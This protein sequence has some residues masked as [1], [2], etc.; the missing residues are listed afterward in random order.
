[1][2]EKLRPEDVR[3]LAYHCTEGG[4][5]GGDMTRAVRYTL[6]A[7]EES[8]AA[9]AFADAEVR[10]R[11]ALELLED[12]EDVASAA[13]VAALCGLGEAQR[14]QGDAGF[15]ET[16]LDASRRAIEMSNIDLLVRAVLSNTRGFAS[17][18]GGIDV[19]RLEVIDR[20]LELV[21]TAASPNR[22][23]LLGQLASEL[24]FSGQHE[25]RLALADDAVAMAR[26]FG[27]AVLLGDV[28]VTTGYACNSSDRWEQL[29]DRT[30]ESTR[31]ADA[32]GDPAQRVVARVFL[33][34]ALLTAGRLDESSQVTR[35]MGAIAEAEGSPLIRWIALSNHI[36]V[37]ALAG[38]LDEAEE[39]NDR[40]LALSRELDQHD[41]E[42]WWAA[43]LLGLMWLRGYAG[44][45]ADAAADFA[46]QFPLA[47][48][49]R[50]AQAWLLADAGRHD[51]ARAV[52]RDHALDPAELIVEPWPFTAAAQLALTAFYLGDAELGARVVESIVDHP[53]CWS[54]YYLMVF[55]PLSWSMGLATAA[56]GA[57]DE[58][59]THLERTLVVLGEQGLVA[60][61]PTLR[62]QLAQVLRRRDG[63]GDAERAAS[64]LTAARDEAVAIGAGG[65]VERIDALAEAL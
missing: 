34:S 32:N 65:V 3:A 43:G 20:A 41:G 53:T 31:L 29:V 64:L 16:L 40:A 23:R 56:T 5:D 6:A 4:P 30:A 33:S 60:F 18:V 10:F 42:M 45:Y 12:A 35:D 55:G 27:D 26:S 22:A 63:A 59:I 50:C 61:I 52:I 48:V 7:A 37:P 51:E 11:S 28:L 47:K 15:R 57:H 14:D 62:L 36:R 44:T 54:H 17:I 46:E 58:A 49:W 2:L 38:R 1:V 9:R 25:R 8:L 24:T 39:V 13:W 19:E 21:G